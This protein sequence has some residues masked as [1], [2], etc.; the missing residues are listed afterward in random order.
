MKKK[1]KATTLDKSMKSILASTSEDA[2]NL[3]ANMLELESAVAN[4]KL[5]VM[6]EA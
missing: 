1:M 6:K 2:K 3:E 4:F 5:K